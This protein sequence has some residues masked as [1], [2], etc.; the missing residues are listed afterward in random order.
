M[1]LS[2]DDL[3]DNMIHYLVYKICCSG[4]VYMF[5]SS[6]HHSQ[7]HSQHFEGTWKL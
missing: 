4:Q 5:T 6:I 1:F 7:H 2:N 3:M